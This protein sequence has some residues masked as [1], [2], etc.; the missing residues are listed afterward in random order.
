VK[1]SL[2][3][4]KPSLLFVSNVTQ[5]VRSRKIASS[6]V[7]AE[8][9]S[10]RCKSHPAKPARPI[11]RRRRSTHKSSQNLVLIAIKLLRPS[12]PLHAYNDKLNT[13]APNLHGPTKSTVH[14]ISALSLTSP[15]H[16]RQLASELR[17]LIANSSRS[18][19]RTL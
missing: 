7:V 2:P 19:R 1:A 14:Q 4:S 10:A 8:R 9:E 15:I 5:Q 12:L 18:G 13:S 6:S 16:L 17:Q 11:R 3:W